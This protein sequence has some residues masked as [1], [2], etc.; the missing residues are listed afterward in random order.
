MILNL[1]EGLIY[2]SY[3]FYTVYRYLLHFFNDLFI[4]LFIHLFINLLNLLQVMLLDCLIRLKIALLMC[5]SKLSISKRFSMLVTYN[6]SCILPCSVSLMFI[7][8]LKNLV[9][10]LFLALFSCQHL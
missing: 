4:Y 2:H 8:L 7:T 6:I 9:E 5:S 3:R 10:C 1:S